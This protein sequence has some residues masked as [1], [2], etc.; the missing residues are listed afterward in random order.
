M[1]GNGSTA[2]A[3]IGRVDAAVAG[4]PP[5]AFAFVMA[6]AITAL[7]FDL[8]DQA[9][10]SLTLLVFAVTGGVVLVI[11]TVWRLASHRSNVMSDAGNPAK[12]FGFF[13]TVAAANV[14]GAYLSMSGRF[15]GFAVL[16][17]FSAVLWLL[18][19]YAL[20]SAV[21]L[22]HGDKSVMAD[23]SGSWFLWVVG[24]QSVATSAAIAAGR[25]HPEIMGSIAIGLWGVGIALYLLVATLVTLRML[26]RENVPT[27]LSPTYWIYMGATAISVLAGSR[28][29][30]LPADL[31]IMQAT[32]HFVAGMSYVLWSLGLWWIPLLLIFG[33]W[34]HMVRRVP[35]KYEAALWSIVFPLGMYS[36]ASMLYGATQDIAFMIRIG[37]TGIWI[38]GVIW[39]VST[40]VMVRSGLRWFA[41][42]QAG[43]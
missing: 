13:T 15:T 21:V 25:W 31:P 6:S 42:G 2:P 36:V 5:S 41:G 35:L 22:G 17:L 4:L 30:L 12:T 3:L 7:G 19:T 37:Q 9:A 23:V 43:G 32:R 26:V 10:I 14:I 38:A 34:R 11:A 39:M 40:V 27:G 18:L 16:A 20:P 28:I 29:L 8:L 33:L 24:T 1:S